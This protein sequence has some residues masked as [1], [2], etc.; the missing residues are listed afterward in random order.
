MLRLLAISDTES[1]LADIQAACASLDIVAA[2]EVR[3]GS[4]RAGLAT[5]SVEDFDLILLDVT[6]EGSAELD[7]WAPIA[8]RHPNAGAVLL[9][10]RDEPEVLRKA[11]RM[12]VLE[13]IQLPV[14]RTEFAEVI[15]RAHA[16]AVAASGAGAST[17]T[18]ARPAPPATLAPPP[19]AEP[20]EPTSSAAPTP[21]PAP[22]AAASGASSTP[23][24]G[25]IH[26]FT[27]CKGG[28]GTTF[29]AANT[30]YALAANPAVRVLLIDL[31][32]QFGDAALL[33]SEKQPVASV[34]DIVRSISTL[35]RTLIDSSVLEVLPNYFVLAAPEDPIPSNGVRPPDVE[36][37]LTFVRQHFDHIVL[38]IGQPLE[39]NSVQALD[40]ADTVLPVLQQT[41]PFVRDGKRLVEA[42]TSLDYGENKIHPI[43]NRVYKDAEVT[44]ADIERAIGRKVSVTVPADSKA[45]ITSINQGVALLK[46]SPDNPVS[47]AIL[48]IAADLTAK[49]EP[50]PPAGPK[51]WL[52]RLF[53]KH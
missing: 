44:I 35:D 38:D 22:P 2:L 30:G 17:P 52:S 27:S 5:V 45:A 29:L 14:N 41:L 40:M 31:N 46:L 12:G 47:R 13:V 15:E 32:P 7:A 23:R 28:A 9:I 20:L 50:P 3:Q 1:V 42:F 25:H 48:R 24:L 53:R 18:V 49:A 6:R 51:A 34:V 26:V 10:E 37:L 36:A 19:P 8:R 16:A 4:F 21:R 43:V 33:L 11:L 39:A